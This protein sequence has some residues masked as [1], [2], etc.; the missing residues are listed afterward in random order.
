MGF[1]T[2]QEAFPEERVEKELAWIHVAFYA[3]YVSAEPWGAK[4]LTPIPH[5]YSADP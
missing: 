4:K 5:A 1:L 2:R 3:L